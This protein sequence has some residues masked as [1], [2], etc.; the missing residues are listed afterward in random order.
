MSLFEVPYI[1]AA[2]AVIFCRCCHLLLLLARCCHRRNVGTTGAVRA[3]IVVVAG[4]MLLLPAR[5]V[6]ALLVLLCSCA[7]CAE[8]PSSYIKVVWRCGVA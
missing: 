2:A 7:S 1:A 5:L 8:R 6:P 3:D 4:I